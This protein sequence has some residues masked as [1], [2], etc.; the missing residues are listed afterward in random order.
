MKEICVTIGSSSFDFY[1]DGGHYPSPQLYGSLSSSVESNDYLRMCAVDR[2]IYFFN[3]VPYLYSG[4]I[5]MDV[6]NEWNL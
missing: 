1:G 4:R 2:Q 5:Q 6:D 3:D